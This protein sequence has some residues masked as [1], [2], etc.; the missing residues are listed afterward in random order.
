M[1]RKVELLVASAVGVMLKVYVDAGCG[2]VCECEEVW[3]AG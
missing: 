1:K 3:D 2:Y